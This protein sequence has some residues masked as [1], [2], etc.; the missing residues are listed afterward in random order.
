[1]AFN[2]EFKIQIAT[3]ANSIAVQNFLREE[4]VSS[5]PLIEGFKNANMYAEL[6]KR[7]N[8]RLFGVIS[9]GLTLI[10]TDCYEKIIGVIESQQYFVDKHE[11][12]PDDIRTN[13]AFLQ[14]YDVI[15]TIDSKIS[16][17]T[18]EKCNKEVV[19][20]VICVHKDWRRKGVGY[21]LLENLIDV[22]RQK[23][24]NQIRA[25]CISEYS[26]KLLINKGFESVCSIDYEEFRKQGRLDAVPPHPHSSVTGVILML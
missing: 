6:P 8:S 7:D 16:A 3:G 20:N 5:S 25:I 12:I 13:R 9:E 19:I 11:E 23:R 17:S 22:V 21:A 1:M 18:K 4:F 14:I 26:T 10:A 15:D 24:F 2:S